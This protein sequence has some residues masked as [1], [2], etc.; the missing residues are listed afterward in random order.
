MTDDMTTG[1][2]STKTLGVALAVLTVFAVFFL[3][4]AD[5]PNAVRYT[6]G[7]VAVVALVAGVFLL[8]S[9]RRGR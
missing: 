1:P 3:L 8:G 7:A 5:L 2:R 9:G 6:V 4:L